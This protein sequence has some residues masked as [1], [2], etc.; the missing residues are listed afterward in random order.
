MYWNFVAI[1]GVIKNQFLLQS[2]SNTAQA[3]HKM[4]SCSETVSKALKV[5]LG[6]NMVVGKHKQVCSLKQNY[7]VMTLFT[8]YRSEAK[9]TELLTKR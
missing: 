5:N 6:F 7:A 9:Y 1:D 4:L 2:P 3:L 8:E